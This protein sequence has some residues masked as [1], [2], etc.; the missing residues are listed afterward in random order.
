MENEEPS[1][2]YLTLSHACRKFGASGQSGV[3]TRTRAPDASQL[4]ENEIY[5]RRGKRSSVLL[6]SQF[7]S[8]FPK[9][10]LLMRG[11]RI[12]W[13]RFSSVCPHLGL[14]KNESYA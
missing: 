7:R 8:S 5:A 3:P 2:A 10:V 4:S 12:I 9:S 14:E 1:R 13:L 6:P 11:S